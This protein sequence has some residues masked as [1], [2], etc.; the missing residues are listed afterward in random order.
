MC[1]YSICIFIQFVKTEYERVDTSCFIYGLIVYNYIVGV[2]YDS[3]KSYESSFMMSGK[4]LSL[5]FICFEINSLTFSQHLTTYMYRRHCFV[6]P[7]YYHQYYY[8]LTL[9]LM[10]WT[11]LFCIF[12][13]V[14]FY[15]M[16]VKLRAWSWS[17]NSIE[18]GDCMDMQCGQALYWWQSL[19][20][21]GSRRIKC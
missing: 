11:I 10:K 18:H 3:T 9:N 16:D 1:I 8:L 20:T 2:L 13:T 21:F 7:D 17:A 14:H 6:Y 5:N 19:I 12:G 15:F 4:S